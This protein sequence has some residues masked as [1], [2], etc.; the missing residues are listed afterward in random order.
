MAHVVLLV[1][2]QNIWLDC[3]DSIL[4]TLKYQLDEKYPKRNLFSTI[5]ALLAFNLL[6]NKFDVISYISQRD[7]IADVSLHKHARRAE[8][9]VFPNTPEHFDFGAAGELRFIFMGTMRYLPNKNGL[10]DLLDFLLY[11]KSV[12]LLKKIHVFGF[13]FENISVR[14]PEVNWHGYDHYV[15]SHNDV[16]IAP[17]FTGAGIKNKV[18]NPLSNNLRVITTYEGANGIT[19]NANLI[20]T[21]DMQEFVKSMDFQI[22]N[23]TI[24]TQKA[25]CSYLLDQKMLLLEHIKNKIKSPQV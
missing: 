6:R 24:S 10:L 16:H 25:E 7:L 18:I 20:V 8:K 5:R 22:S 11:S 9:F 2:Y 14:Y 21:S 4:T 23:L 19:P 12:Q 15:A 1:K 17:I 13:T 3:T